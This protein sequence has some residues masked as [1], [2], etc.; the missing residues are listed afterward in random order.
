M[1]GRLVVALGGRSGGGDLMD[2]PGPNV[3]AIVFN[4]APGFSKRIATTLEP[5]YGVVQR[6]IFVT[7]HG[8]C[9]AIGVLLFVRS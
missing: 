7:W 1:G 3:C 6:A 8:W 4:L 2:R 5:I 9:A